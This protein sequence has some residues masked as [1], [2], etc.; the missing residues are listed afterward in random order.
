[1]QHLTKA[2][3]AIAARQKIADLFARYVEWFFLADDGNSQALKHNEIDINVSHG[4]LM[5][6]CWTEE[7]TRTW[8]IRA[9]NWTGE[10]FVF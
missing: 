2:S 3:A 5:L 10:K 4:R 8:T 1:M 6:S 7:G 9:W